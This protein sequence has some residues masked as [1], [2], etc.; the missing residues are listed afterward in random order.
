MVVLGVGLGRAGWVSTPLTMLVILLQA[1]AKYFSSAKKGEI[2]DLKAELNSTKKNEKKD[3]VK[4]VNPTLPSPPLLLRSAR[5]TH[6]YPLSLSLV[7]ILAA[8]GWRVPLCW[9][10]LQYAISPTPL[11]LLSS[12]HK[13]SVAL[14]PHP[15]PVCTDCVG[16]GGCGGGLRLSVALRLRGSRWIHGVPSCH[17]YA[18]HTTA[19]LSTPRNT[20]LSHI[21]LA[22]LLLNEIGRWVSHTQHTTLP[23]LHN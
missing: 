6:T 8:K 20:I 9:C 7:F 4:K 23:H 15:H 16:R 18:S 10:A 13:C 11:P 12:L 5:H 14:I 1:D 21:T 2:A 17:P 19:L 22:M 3:A